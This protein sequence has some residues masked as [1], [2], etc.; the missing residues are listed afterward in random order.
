MGIT[1]CPL[2]RAELDWRVQKTAVNSA[3]PDLRHLPGPN[4][5]KQPNPRSSSTG[6]VPP[7]KD[8]AEGTCKLPAG[9]RYTDSPVGG[10]NEHI[11][12]S[13]KGPSDLIPYSL[14]GYLSLGL[15]DRCVPQVGTGNERKGRPIPSVGEALA[16]LLGHSG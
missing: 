9:G 1:M 4:N 13:S 10:V 5:R 12:A 15:R 14:C 8:R 2:L 11:S 7:R 3:F 6:Q 16:G